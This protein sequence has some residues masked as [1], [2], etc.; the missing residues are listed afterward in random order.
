MFLTD[1]SRPGNTRCLGQR[2]LG[3]IPSDLRGI[4]MFES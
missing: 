2:R 4:V 3:S 1:Q